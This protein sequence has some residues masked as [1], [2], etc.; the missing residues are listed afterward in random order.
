MLMLMLTITF[1]S[2]VVYYLHVSRRSIHHLPPL[3]DRRRRR[4]MSLTRLICVRVHLR[5]GVRDAGG[6]RPDAHVGHGAE[7]AGVELI[8]EVLQLRHREL[9]VSGRVAGTYQRLRQ[10]EDGAQAHVSRVTV[11]ALIHI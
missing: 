10:F 7:A 2:A 8:I 3:R 5:R 6:A 1:E 11:R 4:L 9:R